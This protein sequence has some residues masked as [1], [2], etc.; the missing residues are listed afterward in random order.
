M[1]KISWLEKVTSEEVLWGV[2]EDRQKLNSIC[3]VNIEGLPMF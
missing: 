2:N 1:D 3:K